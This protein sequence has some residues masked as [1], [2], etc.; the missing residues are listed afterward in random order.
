MQAALSLPVPVADIRVIEDETVVVLVDGRW[1]GIEVFVAER[2][3]GTE[4]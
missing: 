2:P 1:F 4:H 3:R